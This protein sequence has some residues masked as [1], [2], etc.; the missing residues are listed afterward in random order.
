[1]I[2]YLPVKEF[3]NSTEMKKMLVSIIISLFAIYTFSQQEGVVDVNTTKKLTKEQKLELRR[4]E[5]AA[6][7]RMVD[8]LVAKRKFV[9]EADFLSNQTGNRVV[10]NSLINFIA[11]DSSKIVIQ[12]ASTTG[13][14]G[15][16]G[17]GGVTTRGRISKL[18]VRKTGK[19]KDFYWIRLIA[20]T[21]LGTYDISFNISPDSNTDASISGIT[22]GKLNY[23]GYIKPLEKSKVYQGMTI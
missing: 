11:L 18:E 3:K 10:V 6:T 8:S 9:L 1:L 2:E 23:H 14:G 15:P 5:E 12:I 13:I 21:T 19:N 7:A 16:N 4:A 22:P 17:M 20:N